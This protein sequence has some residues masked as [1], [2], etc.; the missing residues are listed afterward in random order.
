[1][2]LIKLDAI[3]STNQYLSDLH[4]KSSSALAEKKKKTQL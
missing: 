2:Q 1:M 3:D 4:S